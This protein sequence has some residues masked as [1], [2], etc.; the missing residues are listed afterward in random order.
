MKRLTKLHWLLISLIVAVIF[1][2]IAFYIYKS[3]TEQIRNEKFAYLNAISNLKIDQLTKW[4]TERLSESEFFPSRDNVIRSTINLSKNKNDQ[5]SIKYLDETLR[6]IQQR[7]KYYNIFIT[8]INHKVLFTLKNEFT[9]IDTLTLKVIY[10]SIAKDSILFS[11][12]YYCNTHSAI[13]LDIVSPIKNFD[14]KLIGT[15]VLRFDPRDYLYP[16][17]QKWPTPSKSGESLLLRDNDSVITILSDVRFKKDAALSLTLPKRDTNYISAKAF[18]SSREVLDGIDYRRVKVLAS[19]RKIEGSDWL[20]VSKIDQDEIFEDLR[21]R[22]VA[23]TLITVIAFLFFSTVILYL[24]K[25]RQSQVYKDLFYKEKELNEHQVKTK[26]ITDAAQDAI[27]MMDEKGNISF[28][29][30]SA[31]RILGY[32]AEEVVNKNLHTILAPESYH[33]LHNNAF[34]QFK[35]SGKGNAI[36]SVMEF[37]AIR[38]DGIEVPIELSLSAINNN[39]VWNSV[40]IIR[41]ITERK[42]AELKLKHSEEKFRKAFQTSPDSININR[43]SD[44]LYIS[45]NDGYINMT[46]YSESDVVGKTSLEINIWHN[47]EDR[48][49]LVNGLKENGVVENLEAQFRMKDGRILDG[50]MSASVIKLNNELHIISITRDI[51]ERKKLESILK[52]SEENY[53]QIINGMQDAVYVI[54]FNGKIIDVNKAAVDTLGYTKEEFLKLTP[55]DID[56]SLSNEQIK[57]LIEKIPV[58]EKQSFQTTHITKNKKRIPVEINS[59]MIIY[60]GIKSILSIARDI[61]PWLQAQEDIYRSESLLKQTQKLAK[62]GGW[63]Y[64]VEKNQMYWTDECFRIHGVNSLSIKSDPEE[65]ISKSIKCYDE[66]DKPIVMLAFNRCVKEGIPYDSEFPFTTF[67]NEKIWIRTLAEPVYFENNIIKVI[68]NIIDITNRKITEEELRKSEERYSRI[69]NT[70]NEGIWVMNENHITTFVNSSLCNILGYSANEIIGKKVENFMFTEDLPAH[71]E[72]MKLRHRGESS[73]YE[74]RFCC[75]DGSEVN[76]IVSGVALRDDDGKF[77]GSFGMFTDITERKFAEEAL[78]ESEEKYRELFESLHEGFSLHEIILDEIGTPVDYRFLEVNKSFEDMTGLN[79]KDIK[80]KTVKEVIPTIDNYWI[81]TYGNVALT[82]KPIKIENYVKELNKYFRVHSY[83][84]SKNRFACITEDITDV[85]K[86]EIKIKQL[87]LAVEQN[88]ATVVITDTNGIIEYVNPKFTELTQY[89]LEDVIGKNPSVLKSGHTTIDEYKS[90]WKT[91][92]SGN[93]WNGNFLNKKKDGQL[94][95]ES[96]KISPLRNTNGTITH[97]VAIK[98]DITQRIETEKELTEYRE[99]LESIVKSRTKEIESINNALLSEIEKEKQTEI[100]LQQSLEKEKELSELKSRFISTAS[101]EF[102]TPLTTILSS[103]ELIQRYGKKWEEEKY[104]DHL[105]RITNSV[106]YLTNLMDDVLTISRIESGKIVFTPVETDLK[107]ICNKVI[108]DFKLSDDDK[109]KLEFNYKTDQTI[110]NIDQKQVQMILQNLLSNAF[111]Y[112]N[113]GDKIEFTVHTDEN[114]LQLKVADTGLGISVNDLPHLFEPFYRSL[115]TESIQG[116]GLGLSIVKNAVELHG[117]TITVNSQLGKG[118]TF[119]VSIPL[120]QK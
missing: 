100:L 113:A 7:H 101:H 99:N 43:L 118:S 5:A 86:N 68:G 80:G 1:S 102:R 56:D 17:I 6:P 27:I 39:G 87:S 63:E 40:G 35:S 82:G 52:E 22:T 97:F 117:G 45:V 98:E 85:K 19:I 10:E 64:D 60:R 29:N 8:G 12:I 81:E 84:P 9:A 91:I 107:E 57:Q 70:A 13:H 73:N 93:E 36:G 3:E 32:N 111:K 61:T 34:E 112:S 83:S 69:V 44:G 50:L 37:S 74:H 104:L 79:F 24:Y 94:F 38:K 114:I 54:G 59:T 119:L 110:F 15:M 75:K 55:N 23:I 20:L 116:T 11:E 95:W 106:D 96:A 53:H 77:I 115:N 71:F 28:W 2:S 103:A 92:K 48:V 120:G 47:P 46:G 18:T 105:Q 33:L 90:M 109:H 41:D 65:Y 51:S 16:L 21:Y 30:P 42:N 62:V 58:E 78:L 66:K 88:P 89:T 31:V 72:R 76:T 49:R 108:S 4:R 14:G 25:N 26:A 67:N